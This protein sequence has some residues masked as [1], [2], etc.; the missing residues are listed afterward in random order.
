MFARIPFYALGLCA[1]LLVSGLEGFAEELA[2]ASDELEPSRALTNQGEV[3]AAS[4]HA[5]GE[6]L[7]SKGIAVH[8][9]TTDEVAS[10]AIM[11]F[12]TDT[13]RCV[14]GWLGDVSKEDSHTS[15]AQ[16]VG[17]PFFLLPNM[18][19]WGRADETEIEDTRIEGRDGNRYGPVSKEAG[20]WL[21]YYRSGDRIIWSY[22]AYETEV[23]ES[24][25]FHD[26]EG[27]ATFLR[28]FEIGPRA[29]DLLLN[30][31]SDS[32]QSM[33]IHYE[34]KQSISDQVVTFRPPSPHVLEQSRLEQGQDE[35]AREH[36]GDEE[37]DDEAE[38]EED[39]FDDLEFDETEFAKSGT[40]EFEGDMSLRI[41]KH[42][43]FRTT[44]SDYTIIAR[45][46]TR[47]GGTI[48]ANTPRFAEYAP[49]SMCLFVSDGV[50]KLDVGWIGEVSSEHDVDDGQWHVVAA[51]YQHK[52]GEVCLYVDGKAS[53]SAELRPEDESDDRL[54]PRIGFAAMDFP[55]EV[56]GFEGRIS[57]LTFYDR[58]LN[59]QEIS[60]FSFD[61]P[62]KEAL[63][64]H[65]DRF[66]HNEDV[67]V[68]ASGNGHHAVFE[69]L[70]FEGFDEEDDEDEEEDEPQRIVFDGR[71]T[72][73]EIAGL[74]R[75]PEARFSYT[76]GAR[77]KTTEGGPIFSIASRKAKWSPNNIAWFIRDGRLVFDMGFVG[78]VEG[79]KKIDDGEWHD[80]ALSYNHQSGEVGFMIDG[81]P[82]R[83]EEILTISDEN[84]LLPIDTEEKPGPTVGWIGYASED[85]PEEAPKYFSGQ[86]SQLR[87]YEG[88]RN[89]EDI[90][91][92]MEMSP[93]DSLGVVAAWTPNFAEGGFVEDHTGNDLHGF[94]SV[95]QLEIEE[96]EPEFALT[97]CRVVG[98]PSGTKW[99][100]VDGGELRLH[101]PAGNGPITFSVAYSPLDEEV[102][103]M[104]LLSEK[105]GRK[106]DGT[107]LS[108]IV[109]S[110]ANISQ[111][112]LTSRSEVLGSDKN[113]FVA[114]RLNIFTEEQQIQPQLFSG[115][116][117][118]PEQDKAAVCTL[119]GEVWTVSGLAS[120]ASDTYRWN[121]IALGLHRP[122]GLRIVGGQIYVLG[123]DQITRLHDFNGDGETDYYENFNNDVQMA[124][125]S[126][127]SFAGFD[128]D[129]EGNFYYAQGVPVGH[130]A[131]A[132]HDGA[133]LR[134]SADGLSTDIVAS[135]IGSP[136]G[137]TRLGDGSF[138]VSGIKDRWTPANWI[139]RVDAGRFY[140]HRGSFD[141]PE[142]AHRTLPTIWVHGESNPQPTGLIEVTSDKWGPISNKLLVLS[143][144]SNRIQILDE[145]SGDVFASASLHFLPTEELP[146][147]VSAGRFHP[148]D[149]QLYACGFRRTDEAT[150]VEGGLY[151]ISYSGIRSAYPTKIAADTS[152]I[153]FEFS[154]S[155]DPTSATDWRNYSV[156]R[157]GYR[158][159]SQI[160]SEDY[161]I[162]DPRRRGRDR[163]LVRDAKLSL[164][165]RSLSLI[166]DE[167][168]P[169]DQLQINADIKSSS[170]TPVAFTVLQTVRKATD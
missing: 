142:D 129:A 61:K 72:R 11:L 10:T 68:D 89:S 167:M 109:R 64:A 99:M 157:W 117:F 82:D 125:Y 127:N 66:D 138:W 6:N 93:D 152:G 119:D 29:H 162:S 150:E 42:N 32:S 170:G 78:Q 14:T 1:C 161:R 71:S 5:R 169:A 54:V 94:V 123:L 24:P 56:R 95:S 3:V 44:A 131:I 84:S 77:I 34:D 26:G 53:G 18:P 48:F 112:S 9:D 133:L 21:G 90:A 67:F 97:A 114:E 126:E 31:A 79:W 154:D 120:S 37:T 105:W 146:T 145:Q 85:F 70:D 55:D 136:S 2:D 164:D 13:L 159:S 12:D 165:G 27:R 96:L 102:E 108:S 41:A 22:E 122:Q 16:I 166:L 57:Q 148:L 111:I 118:F 60:S 49:N 104:T 30:I 107:A 147:L 121:R 50:L 59:D 40:L 128:V 7:A 163:L 101:I 75:K 76:I 100:V 25:E 73:I 155:L 4:F 130:D 58:T 149:G 110:G 87:V 132:P 33:V 86:I 115:I 62:S 134:V 51:T 69:E 52:T 74:G 15:G 80:I 35:E 23:L 47:E 46:R 17:Q 144:R 137:V 158:T 36:K 151:R 153:S 39:E 20:K 43:A 83:I 156:S 88:V 106:I 63:V 140:G 38:D 19:G 113:A 103:P 91:K 65:W 45:M 92:V 124:S 168:L 143:S 141:S 8:L 116:D 139:G 28:H 81:E 160:G 98:A 135:G